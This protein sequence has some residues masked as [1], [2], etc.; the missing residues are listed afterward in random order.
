MELTTI[1]LAT[2]FTPGS[3]PAMHEAVRIA[4]WSVGGGGAVRAVHVIDPLVVAELEEA[5]PH[6]GLH[7]RDSIAHDAARAWREMTAGIPALAQAPL[8]VR[9]EPRARGIAGFATEVK[10]DLLVMGARGSRDA[11]T[12]GVG[13]VAAAVVRAAR[14]P[15]LLVRPRQ[16]GAFRVVI[17]CIDFSP[18]SLRALDLAAHVAARDGAALHVIHTFAPPWKQLH[19][20]APTPEA[21]PHFQSEY[22]R[23]LQG[24]LEGFA[25]TL[26]RPLEDL[27][28]LYTLVDAQDHRSGIADYAE[29]N[30]ADLVV[31]GTR[32]RTNL[33]DL[34]LGST[35]EKVLSE[36]PCSILAVP[37]K[38]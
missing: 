31:L 4:A 2:D 25:A 11:S 17:A 19:Y 33:R 36:A 37:P 29:A 27:K 6:H 9:V 34:F 3:L 18:T 15:T 7:L 24:R 13:T 38:A 23:S 8:E 5:M 20:R 14:V 12:T 22:R 10:A 35:A 32:G 30:H 16:E 1:L 21:D 28:P 26:G